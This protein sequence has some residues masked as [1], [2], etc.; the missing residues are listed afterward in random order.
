MGVDNFNPNPHSSILGPSSFHSDS[1]A[2]PRDTIAD[3]RRSRDEDPAA[4]SRA[5]DWELTSSRVHTGGDS[6]QT[7]EREDRRNSDGGEEAFAGETT[8]L[9]AGGMSPLS[10]SDS[11]GKLSG[12]AEVELQP[13]GDSEAS[14]GVVEYKLYK[15]RFIGLAALCL[16]NIVVSW[17]WLT[18]APVASLTV[19]WF[20]LD[21]ES[22]VNWI[23]TVVLFSYVAAT[24]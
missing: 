6:R 16:L 17:G 7:T 4:S 19:E 9:L 12:V 3:R 10:R 22:P 23:S 8:G 5:E 14:S 20:E 11:D 2:W 18:F 24:P 21:N 13:G 15:R 1:D